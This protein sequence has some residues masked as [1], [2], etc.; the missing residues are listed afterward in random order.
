MKI[1]KSG[2]QSS[3]EGEMLN[4]EC[5]Q[6]WNGRTRRRGE[7]LVGTQGPHVHSSFQVEDEESPLLK[8]TSNVGRV[9]EAYKCI[10]WK[11]LSNNEK[12][13]RT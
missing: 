2:L 4:F 9:V 1:T 5:G 7:K 10:G 8:A 11:V 13:L 6:L 3:F 12:R